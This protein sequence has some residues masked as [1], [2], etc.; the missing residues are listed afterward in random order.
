MAA[1]AL[2]GILPLFLRRQTLAGPAGISSRILE[3]HV[4]DRMIAQPGRNRAALPKLQK[5]QPVPRLIPAGMKKAGKVIIG[6]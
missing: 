2:R 6:N 4:N 5:I 3:V 1:R